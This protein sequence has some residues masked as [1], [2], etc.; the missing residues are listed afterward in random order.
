M[1][2]R[3]NKVYRFETGEGPASLMQLFEGRS[4][5]L[6]HH[7]T[8]GPDQ[9]A[10]CPSCSAAADGFDGS[11]SRLAERG[12]TLCAVSPAPLPT[13]NAYKRR[14]GWSFPWVSSFGSDFNHDFRPALGRPGP[15]VSVFALEGG[16]VFHTDSAYGSEIG[17]LLGTYLGL[18]RARTE[19]GCRHDEYCSR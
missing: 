15:G 4:R 18:G 11:V 16:T 8:F 6:L 17:G 12:V 10:G 9:D 1:R 2:V 7:F 5:L 19:P 3:I 13:L 14:M